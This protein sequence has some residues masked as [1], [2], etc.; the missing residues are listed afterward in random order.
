MKLLISAPLL[1]L[2]ACASIPKAELGAYTESF[3]AVQSAAAP[4]LADYAVAERA[5]RQAQLRRTSLVC[6][7]PPCP[8]LFE[9]GYYALFRI[10]D[11]RAASTIGLP[12]GADALER[13]LRSVR[14]YNETLIALAE[15]RNIDEARGQLRAIVADLGPLARSHTHKQDSH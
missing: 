10:E 8:K 2:G 3:Q 7:T 12:P 1:L 14:A 9:H 4:L 11:A 15:G 5:A 13:A 6:D